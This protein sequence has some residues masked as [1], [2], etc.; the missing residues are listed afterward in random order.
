MKR[1]LSV[2]VLLALVVALCASASSCKG[3]SDSTGIRDGEYA[4]N[5]PGGVADVSAEMLKAFSESGTVKVYQYG[6]SEETNAK[7]AKFDEYFNDVYGGKVERTVLPW[8]GWEN[9]FIVDYAANDAPDVIYIFSGLWPRAGNRRLVYSQ[10]ELAELGVIGLNH[11][12]I[13]NSLEL[14]K[15]NYTYAGDIFAVD[16]YLVT[17][18]VMLVNDTLLA[19]CGIEKTPAQYYKDGLWNWDSF[20]DIMS[21]VV[22]VDKNA[23][24]NVDYRGY[25]GWDPTYVTTANDGYMIKLDDNGKL[26]SNFDDIKVRNGLQM[27]RDISQ[28]GCMVDRGRF[29]EGKTATLVGTHYN[30]AKAIYNNGVGISFDWSVVPYPLGADNTEGKQ[31]GGC[32]AY[33]IVSSTENPQGALNY[34][35]AQS[36]FKSEYGEENPN[37][38]LEYWLD[39]EGDR[40]LDDIRL[41]VR[42]QMWSGVANIWGTQWEF[43]GAIKGNAGIPEI[44]NTFEPWIASHCEVENAYAVN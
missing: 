13:E 1:I 6:D 38:D 15:N 42:E 36:A 11:P 16:V 4:D 44:L 33:S 29:E 9:K 19:D 12:I 40:M 43:W 25:D 31:I 39:D 22:S 2:F 28:K 26:Y 18:Y 14:A 7:N 21:Q 27:Y 24:G 3:T 35:I 34:I 5:V 37:Y 10:R 23:D 32:E 30:M 17:P 41:K 8:N 20:M